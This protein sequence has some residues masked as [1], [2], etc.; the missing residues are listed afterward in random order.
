MLNNCCFIGHLG[1]DPEVRHLSS[2]G[3][4][5]N[6]SL[7]VSERWTDK[8]SGERKEK[9]TWV[10]VVIWNDKLGEVAERYLRKGSKVYVAGAFSVRKWT[11]QDGLDKYATEIVL[12]RFRGEL[13]MLG[14]RKSGDDVGGDT[15]RSPSSAPPDFDD[16]IPF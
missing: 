2:G 7:A 12:G 3:R 14:D 16:D 10:P 4:V 11:G 15:A 13:I 8:S 9:T 1:K 5:V 6:F